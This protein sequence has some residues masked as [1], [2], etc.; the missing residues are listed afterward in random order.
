MVHRW[1]RQFSE[2]RQRFH[3]EL[4]S[5]RPSLINFDLVEFREFFF[6][7]MQER[8]YIEI[9][10]EHGEILVIEP[11]R[12]H[13]W[14]LNWP[15]IWRLWQP[16]R[17]VRDPLDSSRNLWRVPQIARSMTQTV[18]FLEVS[19]VSINRAVLAERV[20]LVSTSD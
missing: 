1:C 19:T 5:G 9:Q 4:R 18:V 6:D 10:W 7:L 17:R 3:D 13:F 15:Q 14:Q 16:F 8:K 2:G 11:S 12:H 20:C